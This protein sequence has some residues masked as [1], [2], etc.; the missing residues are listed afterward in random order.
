MTDKNLLE[1]LRAEYEQKIA[2]MELRYKQEIALLKK[3]N[4]SMRRRLFSSK[5]E[6]TKIIL[7]NPDQLSLFNEVEQESSPELAEESTTVKAHKRTKQRRQR[8]LDLSKAEL[9]TSPYSGNQM[10]NHR[11]SLFLTLIRSLV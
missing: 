11:A 2:E 4:A 8:K 7:P 9:K 6:R 10:L 1:K 3:E 5:S